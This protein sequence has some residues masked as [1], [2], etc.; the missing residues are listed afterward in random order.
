MTSSTTSTN[1]NNRRKSSSEL[2][3]LLPLPPES[4]R[5][6]EAAC[7]LTDARGLEPIVHRF[8]KRASRNPEEVG[9]N[10]GLHQQAISSLDRFAKRTLDLLLASIAIVL[11]WPLMLMIALA[12]RLESRGPAIYPSLRVGKRS[13][14]FACYK[15]RTMIPGADRLRHKLLH[16]NQRQGPFFKMADDPRVTRLGRFLRRYSLDELPQ[17]WNVL[18]GDMS[19]VGPRPHPL[20]DVAQYKPGHEQRLEVT[21]GMTGLWQVTARRDPSFEN[22]MLLDVD[23][24][25]NWS[26]LLDCKILLRTIP[27][28]FAGE[29]L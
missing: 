3:L 15:F 19:L 13:M 5:D 9:S 14:L 20:E 24:I 18:K 22:C 7:D 25:Q 17:L 26:L 11:L 29:G 23:Y 8:A 21:P 1:A 16:L 4:R 27:V 6:L 2:R 12:V 10:C 28:V